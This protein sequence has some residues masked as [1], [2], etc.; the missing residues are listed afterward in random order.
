M[1]KMLWI[2]SLAL[3]LP[4]ALR[5]GETLPG[6]D[7]GC[8]WP[9]ALRTNLL[10]PGCNVGVQVPLG[11]H[12]SLATDWYYP[13]FRPSRDNL[14]CLEGMG[15]TLEGRYWF[16]EGTCPKDRC[17]GPSV[18]LG[19]M[20]GYYDL[21]YRGRGIQGEYAVASV[22]YGYGF[23]IFQDRFRL[24]LAIG[25]GWLHTQYRPYEVYEPGGSLFRLGA[26]SEKVDWIGPV[27]AEV[28][29]VIPLW[30]RQKKE[31]QP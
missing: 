31:G 3:M 25:I 30:I 19:V 8:D 28:S 7:A 9:V 20:A 4:A 5:A 13:W 27:R 14:R 16:R 12:F 29:L 26:W 11:A 17:T 1:R 15:W 22:D 18:A 23:S 21:E 10:V 2:L 6:R 24:M